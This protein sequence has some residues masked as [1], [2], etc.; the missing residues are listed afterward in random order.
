MHR[1]GQ[2]WTLSK[3]DFLEKYL[4]AFNKASK[5]AGKTFYVDGFAGPGTNQIG[6]E[7]RAGSPLIALNTKP[8]FTHYFLVEKDKKTFTSLENRV[9]Q[10]ALHQ[11][12]TLFQADFND[13]IEPILEELPKYAPT[14]FLLDPEG[15][16]LAWSTME[17][18]GKRNKADVFV[19]I[20][21]SGVAR[22]L[23]H[24]QLLTRF[25]GDDSWQYIRER[26]ERGDFGVDVKDDEAYTRHYV[27]RLQTLGFG[28]TKYFLV[29]STRTQRVLH[30]WTFV[31]KHDIAIK[32]A[33]E[34]MSKLSSGSQGRLF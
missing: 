5:R 19:L 4:P 6:K 9:R 30:A 20:S 34:V 23:Q 3:L 32:I 12:T 27:E 8:A 16:E 25:F 10:H 15:L 11:Y 13:V 1:S 2:I 22:N 17:K 21:G 7:V 28:H 24:P 14:F 26:R 31:A 18:I 33:S 29:A